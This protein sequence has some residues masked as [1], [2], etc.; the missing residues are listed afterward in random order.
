MLDALPECGTF[1][2]DPLGDQID[3][4]F[5]RQAAD[6][7]AAVRLDLDQSLAGKT[8]QSLANNV[9]ADAMS[10]GE[11]CNAQPLA[12]GEITTQKLST[13]IRKDPC[14]KRRAAFLGTH[15]PSPI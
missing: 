1:E 12:R 10:A 3:E 2:D 14:D 7:E 6:T 11:R 5:H 13:Q 4:V 9:E 15:R 8:I